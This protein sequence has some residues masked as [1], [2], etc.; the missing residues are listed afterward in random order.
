MPNL[1]RAQLATPTQINQHL[2]LPSERAIAS[3]NMRMNPNILL[4][5][6]TAG[7]IAKLYTA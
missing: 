3:P 6:K 5:D 1:L 4:I 2:V 7:A